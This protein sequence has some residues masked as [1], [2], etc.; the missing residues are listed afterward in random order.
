MEASAFHELFTERLLPGP[1]ELG[2]GHWDMW[3][4]VTGLK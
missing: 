1:E 3:Q 4:L 2:S